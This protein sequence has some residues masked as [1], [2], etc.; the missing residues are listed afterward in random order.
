MN[1]PNHLIISLDSPKSS[2]P[3]TQGGPIWV[4]LMYHLTK[5]NYMEKIKFVLVRFSQGIIFQIF[6]EIFYFII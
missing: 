3:T 5:L 2:I 1:F 4:V 6:I